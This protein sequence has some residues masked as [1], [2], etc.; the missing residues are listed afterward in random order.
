MRSMEAAV[1]SCFSASRSRTG[2]LEVSVSSVMPDLKKPYFIGNF[3]CRIA[4]WKEPLVFLTPGIPAYRNG[5]RNGD[6]GGSR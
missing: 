1:G 5:L 4:P 6:D 2:A 3:M